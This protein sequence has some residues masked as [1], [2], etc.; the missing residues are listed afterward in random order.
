MVWYRLGLR[1][2][3]ASVNWRGANQITI[4][5]GLLLVFVSFRA[6][7]FRARASVRSFT[8]VHVVSYSY[9]YDSRP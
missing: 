8:W 1:T 7:F 9:L 6:S 2:L 4:Q 5:S 3:A